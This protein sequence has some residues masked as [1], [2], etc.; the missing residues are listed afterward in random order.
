MKLTKKILTEMVQESLNEIAL[1]IV[2][3]S[4]KD[5]EDLHNTG[6]IN[7]KG[8]FYQYQEPVEEAAG[9]GENPD[10]LDDIRAKVP[11][12]EVQPV[13]YRRKNKESEASDHP[14]DAW[15]RGFN[16]VMQ[17]QLDNWDNVDPTWEDG[18]GT[19]NHKFGET[20]N[21]WLDTHNPL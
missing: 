15:E 1:K 17:S 9:N 12:L 2:K 19:G 10:G 14:E 16:K 7:K 18:H 6:Q 8:V 21:M 20:V 3:F 13:D 5:M 4:Q 11:G